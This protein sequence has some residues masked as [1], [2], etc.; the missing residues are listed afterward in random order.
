MKT[1]FD[2]D[3]GGRV[4]ERE[5]SQNAYVVVVQARAGGH[6]SEMTIHGR[7]DRAGY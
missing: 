2:S 6:A 7:H 5:P 1:F 4:G 3:Y